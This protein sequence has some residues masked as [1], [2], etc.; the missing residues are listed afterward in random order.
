MKGTALRLTK[1]DRD[2][3]SERLSR[4]PSYEDFVNRLLKPRGG[5][6]AGQSWLT[7]NMMTKWPEEVSSSSN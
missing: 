7:Y 1:A 2:E 4:P 5:P 6:T 3:L